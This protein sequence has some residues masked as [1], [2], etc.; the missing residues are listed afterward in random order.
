MRILSLE[1]HNIR[2]IKNVKINP[3]GE[4]IVVFGPN[5]TGKS[6]IVDAI[7]FL[8]TGKISR[9]TGEGTKSLSL[10]EHGPH[11]D[12]RDDL[13]NTVVTARVRIGSTDATIQ[14][15]IAKPSYL[16]VDPAGARD[17]VEDS[18]RATELGQHILTRRDILEYITAEAGKRAK[19]IMSLLDLESV[20]NLRSVLVTVRNEIESEYNQARTNLELARNDISTLLSLP[21]FSEDACLEEV[22]NLRQILNGNMVQSLSKETIR[23]DL[24]PHPFG[25]VTP[26]LSNNQIVNIVLETRKLLQ[27]TE[28]VASKEVELRDVLAQVHKDAKTKEYMM[29]EMLIRAGIELADESN[30]C[31]LCD[32]EWDGNFRQYLEMK[33]R[34]VEAAKDKH[35][36]INEN[37]A[38][39]NTKLALLRSHI[40]NCLSAHEQFQLKVIDEGKLKEYISKVDSWIETLKDPLR[41][42]G[43]DKWPSSDVQDLFNLSPLETILLN[44]L[45]AALKEM[46]PQFSARQTAWDT[47]TR[48]EDKWEK[49]LQ[50][51]EEEV[52][53]QFCKERA[54]SALDYFEE[55]R[56]SVLE[57]IYDA[58]RNSFQEY[59]QLIH[60]EDEF[61]FTSKITHAGA[62]LK[63][64]VDFYKRGLFP[65][66][67]LH[68]EGHQDSMGLCLF[69]ALNKYLVKNIIE[70]MVLD[71]VVMSIDCNHRQGICCV[72]KERLTDKQL[73]ITTHDSAW[74]KQ[75]RTQGI[76]K[77]RNMIHFT[78]WNIETG[79]IYELDKDLWDKIEE[80]IKK[81]DVPTAAHRLRRNAEM[82]FDD[83]CDFLNANVPYKGSHRWELGDLAPAAISAYKKYLR[84]A[85]ANSQKKGDKVKF[86]ELSK[87][88]EKSNDIIT[89]SLVEQWIINENV[90][91]NRWRTYNKNDFEPIVKIFRELFGLFSCSYCGS[92]IALTQS[93]G[94]SP[95]RSITCNC[96]RIFWSLSDAVDEK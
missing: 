93:T 58:V 80:D 12:S 71:D 42:F 70:I 37:A 10:K 83:V 34:E 29:Y 88:E 27:E 72:L 89:R 9:L 17:V 28:T 57:S 75:L 8:L 31:P 73:I 13:K 43:S 77:Q 5:G 84:K 35:E 36:K 4:N 68:S 22:N 96:G 25:G 26:Q 60:A 19:K 15:C 3:D 66:H 74:A 69:F 52:C 47:L 33:E 86:E 2:G 16:K 45:D 63:F 30:I 1:A 59:Y 90:H 56:D 87:L 61:G 11:V 78:N 41:S 39:I 18:L 23:K 65:P 81:D 76:A 40:S 67:A 20:E 44:P 94:K 51:V 48:M 95:R 64:E 50:L 92:L 82:F 7:D 6:A 54:N 38:F 46:A 91:Y 32:R 79:P 21:A 62:E 49:Y 55:A 85:K 24:T 14:R 53:K